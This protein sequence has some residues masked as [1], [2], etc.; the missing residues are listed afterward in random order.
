MSIR[1][2]DGQMM[3]NRT[4]EYTRDASAQIKQG[5]V[6]QDYL[7]LQNKVLAEQQREQ[8]THLEGKESAGV[9][10]EERKEPEGQSGR[11]RKKKQPAK[12][13]PQ[14]EFVPDDPSVGIPLPKRLDIE[15]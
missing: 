5:E 15:V 10:L 13:E 2:I 7:A 1:G 8:V 14:D 6:T 4:T 3:I 9:R 12:A 11:K